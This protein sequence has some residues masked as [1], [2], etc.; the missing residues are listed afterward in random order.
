[1]EVLQSNFSGCLCPVYN[2]VHP[3]ATEKYILLASVEITLDFRMLF[4]V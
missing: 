1:M 2:A 4:T 3:M